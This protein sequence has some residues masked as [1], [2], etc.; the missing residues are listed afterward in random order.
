MKSRKAGTSQNRPKSSKD[1][2]F[3]P[4]P[5]TS[6]K[7]SGAWMDEVETRSTLNAFERLRIWR[8]SQSPQKTASKAALREAA[9]HR[10]TE[11]GDTMKADLH[12]TLECVV[13]QLNKPEALAKYRTEAAMGRA[14]IAGM[15]RAEAEAYGR[16]F[17][18]KA[19]AEAKERE[20]EIARQ[21]IIDK[22]KKDAMP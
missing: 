18:A 8:K 3:Q 16:A 10:P 13:E 5:V 21:A 2:T 22:L 6:P 14:Y 15:N 19:L 11:K 20:R 4:F 17:Y 1:S 7:Y 9:D 12:D